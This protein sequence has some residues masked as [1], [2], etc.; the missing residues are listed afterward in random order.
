MNVLE[1]VEK[2]ADSLASRSSADWNGGS[3]VSEPDA[4]RRASRAANASSSVG[5]DE[6]PAR[7]T[8]RA[9]GRRARR[10]GGVETPRAGAGAKSAR[11]SA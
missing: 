6:P 9:V 5:A 8:T 10:A 11:D 7:G 1:G 3:A 4:T 2:S